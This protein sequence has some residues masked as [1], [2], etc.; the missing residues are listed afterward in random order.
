LES[1]IVLQ[2]THVVANLVHRNF[3]NEVAQKGDV[4]HTRQPTTGTVKSLT[5]NAAITVATLGATDVSI[6]L[7]KHKYTAFRVSDRDMST[8]IKNLVQEFIEPYTI[9]IAKQVDDDLL[10]SSGLTNSGITSQTAT[11][12]GGPIDLGDFANVRGVLRAAQCPIIRPEYVHGVLGTDHE[13]EALKVEE[14]VQA[15]TYG[16]QN[17]PTIK[18]GFLGNVYGMS[19]FADQGVPTGATTTE[20]QSVFFHKNAMALVTRPLEKPMSGEARTAIVQ[21][22]GVGIRVIMSYDHAYLS[23]LVTYDLLY[24]IKLLNSSLAV[25]LTDF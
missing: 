3:E 21:K 15:N 5:N 24:G 10:G 9:P 11:A 25:I 1:L 6:T 19:I 4:V 12:S 8:S 17:N 23:T 14:L 22:D 16:E 20:N 2:N 7:D 18:T 13:T